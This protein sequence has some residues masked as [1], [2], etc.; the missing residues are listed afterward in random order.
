[1]LIDNKNEYI[2]KMMANS[3]PYS[4]HDYSTT[5]SNLFDDPNC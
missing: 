3:L 5:T 1:M 2:P 4:L